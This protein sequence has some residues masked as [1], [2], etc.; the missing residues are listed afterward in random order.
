MPLFT[1]GLLASTSDLAAIES[2]ILAT[3]SSEGLD[4]RQKLVS[5]QSQLGRDISVFLI[6]QGYVSAGQDLSCVFVNDNLRTA[7]AFHALALTYRDLASRRVQDRFEDKAKF[8]ERSAANA[9]WQAFEAGIGISSAPLRA[10]SGLRLQAISGGTRPARRLHVRA[11]AVASGVVTSAWTSP[12]VIDLEAGQLAEVSLSGKC[13]TGQWVVYASYSEHG[14]QLQT[15]SALA[16]DAKWHEPSTGL[17]ANTSELPVQAP[18][19]W[20][21]LSR[22]LLRG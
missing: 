22:R 3:A 2:A 11:A 16:Q 17:V 13:G 19:M 6:H 7:H 1:D 21:H 9:T 5:A 15:P 20:V 18:E 12:E 4:L 8:Y 14:Y 10:P